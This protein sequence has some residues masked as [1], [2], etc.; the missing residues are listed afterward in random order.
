MTTAFAQAE[1]SP[2]AEAIALSDGGR[3][4]LRPVR[5]SDKARFRRAFEK[6]SSLSRYRRFLAHK[7]AL[8]D[9]DLRFFTEV[10]GE[11]HYAL[12]A[13]EQCHDGK[14]GELVGAARYVRLDDNSDTAEIAVAVVDAFQR[15]GIGKLLLERLRQAAYE[16]GIRRIRVHLMAENFAVRKLLESLFGEQPLRRDGDIISGAIPLFA[17]ESETARESRAPVFELLR[18]AA[19]EAVLP[20]TLSLTLSRAQLAAFKCRLASARA[21]DKFPQV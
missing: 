6:L 2:E 4:L 13:L 18:L 9:A 11:Q 8:S 12:V 21:A 5:P 10:D 14:E 20:V 17:P 16:R 7:N 1:S 3:L 15:R 19:E